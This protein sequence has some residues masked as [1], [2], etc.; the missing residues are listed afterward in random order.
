MASSWQT[1]KSFVS[2]FQAKTFRYVL[3][4]YS[5]VFKRKHSDIS[6]GYIQIVLK[7]IQVC[8]WMQLV[9]NSTSKLRVYFERNPEW[10]L[11]EPWQMEVA[12]PTGTYIGA[13]PS[14]CFQSPS[15]WQ[16][17][18]CTLHQAGQSSGPAEYSISIN[19]LDF[20]TWCFVTHRVVEDRDLN[21]ESN[22]NLEAENHR[23]LNSNIRSKKQISLKTKRTYS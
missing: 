17:L 12:G 13:S 10:S 2:L 7:K 14:L 3:R 5:D 23:H 9:F 20:L 1:G 21:E 19:F 16:Q 8:P 18:R 22:D 4:K 6:G 15:L 11:D